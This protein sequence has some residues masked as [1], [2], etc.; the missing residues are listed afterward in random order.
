MSPG[1]AAAPP[2]PAPMLFSVFSREK[3]VIPPQ[4]VNLKIGFYFKA[5]FSGKDVPYGKFCPADVSSYPKINLLEQKFDV[6]EICSNISLVDL[7]HF[8]SD[9]IDY[10]HSWLQT[11]G[12]EGDTSPQHF[13]H[14]GKL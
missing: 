10:L 11:L 8:T 3:Q 13:R 5:W 2:L 9:E 7:Q 6:F 4:S 12:G 14:G 1:G